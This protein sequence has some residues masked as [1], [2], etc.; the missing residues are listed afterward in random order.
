MSRLRPSK[1]ELVIVGGTAASTVIS[2]SEEQF[3]NVK[4]SMLV[5]PLPIM[6]RPRLKQFMKAP[7]PM[8]P[9]PSGMTI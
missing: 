3:M 1:V 6:T 8:V 2:V 7:E 5:T 9:T 4:L